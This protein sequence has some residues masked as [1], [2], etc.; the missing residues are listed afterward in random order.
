MRLLSSPTQKCVSDWHIFYRS[1]RRLNGPFLRAFANV[2]FTAHGITI[3][4]ELSVHSST[5]EQYIRTFR[6]KLDLRTGDE[7]LALGDRVSEVMENEVTSRAEAFTLPQ[8]IWSSPIDGTLCSVV[9]AMH[10]KSTWTTP[11]VAKIA[12]YRR[13]PVGS[14]RGRRVQSA[15][16]ARIAPSTKR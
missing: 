3:L 8:A 7:T 6:H 4:V 12:G 15:S 9:M 11:Y 10:Q 5:I 13:V 1:D 14:A 2:E 16:D